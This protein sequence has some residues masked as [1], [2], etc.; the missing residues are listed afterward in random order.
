MNPDME[1]FTEN[2]IDHLRSLPDFTDEM[3]FGIRCW[4]AGWFGNPDVI[5][6]GSSP[7]EAS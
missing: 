2:L 4:A 7:T 3:A 6:G 5:A 1:M